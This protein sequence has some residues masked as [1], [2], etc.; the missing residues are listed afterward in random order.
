MA[1]ANGVWIKTHV[2]REGNWLKADVHMVTMGEPTVFTAAVD[3]AKVVRAVKAYHD[4]YLHAARV[5]GEEL[6]ISGCVGCD[7]DDDDIAGLFGKIVKAVKN[8]KATI[9]KAG[10]IAVRAVTKPRASVKSL[11]KTVQSV[12]KSKLVKQIGETA[13]KVIKSKVTAGIV[14]TMAVVYPPVGIPAAAAYAAANV[15]LAAIERGQAIKKTAVSMLQSAQKSGIKPV[16]KDTT[17]ALLAKA[18]TQ[19]KKAKQKVNALI[20]TAKF[21]EDPKKKLEATKMVKVL[22]LVAN[23][24]A[25]VR[26]IPTAAKKAAGKNRVKGLVVNERGGIVYGLF[27]ENPLGRGAALLYRPGKS[28]PGSFTKIGGCIGCSMGSNPW[29]NLR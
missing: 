1:S 28:I 22:E 12:A 4:Q 24:R 13:K 19:E 27:D 20:Q 26:A 11:A 21:S 9:K 7:Y 25:Q 17:K 18:V 10:K 14:S 6:E 29:P 3:M 8:P 16:L 23:N 5:S 2:Y 15:A